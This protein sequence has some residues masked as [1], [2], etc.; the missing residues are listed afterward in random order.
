MAKDKLPV[1]SRLLFA[2]LLLGVNCRF[3]DSKLFLIFLKTGAMLYG[4]G[5][6]LFAYMDEALVRNNHWLSRQQLMDAIA[7]GQITPGPILSSVKLRLF[8]DGLS[9]ASISIIAVVALHLVTSSVQ[10]WQSAVILAVCLAL[11]VFVKNISTVLI[12]LTG[13]LGGFLLLSI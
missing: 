7:V 11:T 3:S 5:Y 13:S 9:A 2:P 6:V 8:L 10:Q 12:I 4:S 1:L